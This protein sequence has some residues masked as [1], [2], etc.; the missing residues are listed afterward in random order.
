M[1]EVEDDAQ[2]HEDIHAQDVAPVALKPQQVYLQILVHP[3]QLAH[4]DEDREPQRDEK[5][6]VE[7]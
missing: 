4:V 5:N 7:V 1:V 2:D 6:F 3:R